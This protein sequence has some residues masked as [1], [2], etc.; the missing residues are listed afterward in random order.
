M[1]IAVYTDNLINT[2]LGLLLIHENDDVF[3]NCCIICL[4][5]S[6]AYLEMTVLQMP[7][8]C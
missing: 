6:V 2:I 4:N 5:C 7:I 3:N 8:L 1:L